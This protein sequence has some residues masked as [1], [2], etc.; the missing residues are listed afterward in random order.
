LPQDQTLTFNFDV[1]TLTAAGLP[2]SSPLGAGT[3]LTGYNWNTLSVQFINQQ[4]KP[5]PAPLKNIKVSGTVLTFDVDFPFTAN[6][7]N[8]LTIAAVTVGQGPFA[9]AGEVAAQT[10]FGPG[11]IEVN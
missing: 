11:L 9:S 10:L 4:N 2:A 3:P 5:V 8:G 6:L 7:L 1:K